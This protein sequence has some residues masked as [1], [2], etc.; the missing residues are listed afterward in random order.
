VRWRDADG[1]QRERTFATE[2]EARRAHAAALT[3]RDAG[4]AWVT[5]TAVR[6]TV[7]EP[8]TVAG[9]LAGWLAARRA[10]GRVTESTMAS[11]GVRAGRV[12]RALRGMLGLSE[13]DPIPVSALSRK[14][15]IDMVAYLPTMPRAPIKGTAQGQGRER[16]GDERK[17][18]PSKATKPISQD[19]VIQTVTTLLD[20]W[21]WALDDMTTYPGVPMAPR[22]RETILPLPTTR[23]AAPAPTLAE[24]DAVLRRMS[25]R[26]LT[27]AIIQR[28]TGLRIEQAM[29]IEVRDLD[30][31]A[32]TL[33]VR[34]GKTKREKLG[35]VV[36]IAVGLAEYLR[37]HIAAEGLA[38]EDRVGQ[39]TGRHPDTAYTAAW[40]AAT[41]AGEV[42]RETWAPPGRAPRPTHAF[43]AAFLGALDAAG[44]PSKVMAHLVGHAT[45]DDRAEALRAG[46]YVAADV[47]RAR[48]AVDALQPID[49]VGPK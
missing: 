48:P 13:A 21:V 1:A 33:A 22:D 8:A 6:V 2:A 20:A 36:P 10:S 5:P 11:L 27:L 19:V 15:A 14:L 49:W 42:R 32:R 24:V 3:A 35:R 29:S 45:T 30:L 40:E 44:T 38:A 39:R 26:A 12:L 34:S 46:H 41:V 37:A 47:E 18:A 7:R 25:G 9:I 43:R 4:E 28:W 17:A 23:T 16:W 31:D